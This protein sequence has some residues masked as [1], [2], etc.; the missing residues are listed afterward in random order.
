M[1]KSC[2]RHVYRDTTMFKRLLFV[3]LLT[4]VL[5]IPTIQ[6]QSKQSTRDN[7]HAF[8]LQMPFNGNKTGVGLKYSYDFTDI[9][10]FSFESNYYWG[11]GNHR[12]FNTISKSGDIGHDYW[13]RHFDIDANLNFVFGDGNFHFYLISGIYIA[14]GYSQLD[15]EVDDAANSLGGDGNGVTIGNEYYWYKEK[16]TDA[17][18]V[19]VGVNLGFGMEYQISEHIRMFL[20]QQ[21]AAG[22]MSSWMARVGVSYCF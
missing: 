15:N 11:M 9:L 19:G 18:K 4:L 17:Y 10:R 6:A 14:L 1:A 8:S 21:L 5:G 22:M 13:G 12:K 20:D 16:V 2:A 3:G 7:K